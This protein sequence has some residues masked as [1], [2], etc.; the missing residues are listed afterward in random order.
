MATA[1]FTNI[2]GDLSNASAWSGGGGSGGVPASGDDVVID[3]NGRAIDTNVT[4]F[5]A[6]V[7]NTCLIKGA[8]RFQG[9][10][11]EAFTMDVDK[12]GA[13]GVLTVQ[14]R[15]EVVFSGDTVLIKNQSENTLRVTGG[16]HVD[17]EASNRG[18][19]IFGAGAVVTGEGKA[20]GRFAP[21]F[22]L[23]ANGTACG[24]IQMRAVG[25]RLT[26]KSRNASRVDTLADGSSARFE[27]T[28]KVTSTGSINNVGTVWQL[29]GTAANFD[30]IDWAGKIDATELQ[31]DTQF[32]DST[33]WET[34][35]IEGSPN[36]YKV[37]INGQ[38]TSNASDEVGAPEVTSVFA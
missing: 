18:G 17:Y 11:G 15:G 8:G 16:A 29:A 26:L 22:V 28:A 2:D 9:S 6:V 30:D 14:G 36:G 12:T 5:S 21:F 33:V 27:G 23:E 20:T 1:T 32:D 24:R 25:S 4:A 31:A 10:N 38:G 7:A 13:T 34:A 37:Q 19:I 35:E 3:R